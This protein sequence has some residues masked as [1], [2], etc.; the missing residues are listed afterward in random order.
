MIVL[1]LIAVIV[2]FLPVAGLLVLLAGLILLLR[3]KR[4]PAVGLPESA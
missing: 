1:G 2:G 4:K 3:A